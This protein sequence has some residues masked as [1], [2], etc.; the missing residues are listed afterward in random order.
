MTTRRQVAGWVAGQLPQQRDQATRQAAAWLK[1]HGRQQETL[2][3][4]EDVA[5]VLAGHGYV[6][7]RI[8]LARAVPAAVKRQ[9]ETQLRRQ[10]GAKQLETQYLIDTNLIG[11][12]RV[13]LPGR[14]LDASVQ[15]ALHGLVE[16]ME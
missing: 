4:A 5:A 14:E 12:L 6:Y 9:L 1:D 7:A 11:G 10:L 16:A 2:Y 15:R 13:E 3:L 8:H